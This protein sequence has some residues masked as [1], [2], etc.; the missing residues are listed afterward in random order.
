[1]V[2]LY[3]EKSKLGMPAP[4]F[5][6]S[7]VDGKQYSLGSF[8]DK[9][10]LL[11][12]FICNHCPYV[13]AVEDRMVQLRKDFQNASFQMVGICSNDPTDYPDDAPASLLKRWKDKDFGFPYL[14][15]VTQDVAK[16]YAAVCTPEFY[17]F[18]EHRKL[19]Y[20]GRL[21]DN[22]KD[23]GQVKKRDLKEAIEA[24]LAG[25]P[26]PAKQEP[27]MGCS[28]KWRAS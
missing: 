22:W 2:L 6:L 28:I 23:A 1:M 19:V 26:L 21:D 24:L 12:S 7:S 13:Q 16:S 27:S 9:K 20:R 4:D 15:D 18:D 3:S 5:K 10:A 25:K 8:K 11:I 14:V 17:L